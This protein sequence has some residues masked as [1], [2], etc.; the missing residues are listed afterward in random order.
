MEIIERGGEGDGKTPWIL[1]IA[2]S[3]EISDGTL[4]LYDKN[5]LRK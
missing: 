5:K 2:D 1:G 4:V 3:H